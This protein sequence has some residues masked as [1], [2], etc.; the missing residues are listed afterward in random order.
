MQTEEEFHTQ[1]K[2]YFSE[3]EKGEPRAAMDPDGKY[4]FVV[5]AFCKPSDATEFTDGGDRGDRS[6]AVGVA[7]AQ[8]CPAVEIADDGKV[9]A[10]SVMREGIHALCATIG[11]KFMTEVALNQIVSQAQMVMRKREVNLD[12]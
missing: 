8:S 9:E 12:A 7:L 3:L 4:A 10:A 5:V 11:A 6:A 2:E 1:L